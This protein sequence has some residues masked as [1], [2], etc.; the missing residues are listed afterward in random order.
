MDPIPEELIPISNPK[1]TEKEIDRFI[2]NSLALEALFIHKLFNKAHQEKSAVYEKS[3][4]KNKSPEEQKT[5]KK[6]KAS[7]EEIALEEQ[8]ALKE[9]KASEEQIASEE[10]RAF[11]KQKDKF[12]QELLEELNQVRSKE[13]QFSKNCNGDY[14]I[15]NLINCYTLNTYY[16][17]LNKRLLNFE[18]YS[19][20]VHEVRRM[21]EIK[22][23]K[24]LYTLIRRTIITAF[25]GDYDNAAK[26]V[27]KRRILD[28]YQGMIRVYSSLYG[29]TEYNKSDQVENLNLWYMNVL[30]YTQ[31]T[32]ID[33]TKNK[34]IQNGQTEYFYSLLQ[35]FLNIYRENIQST[36]ENE[37]K[38]PT[39]KNEEKGVT[40]ESSKNI[41]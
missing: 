16:I 7:K 25:Y 24:T 12:E 1:V 28:I 17:H 5:L 13:S 23:T 15:L 37:K 39:T 27:L 9:Q 40:S 29:K 35:D 20:T 38:D 34:F 8:R 6:Q 14:S 4:E 2:S 19:K 22:L 30:S 33:L 18:T 26:A 11:K 31:N 32:M 21:F 41:I 3:L 36:I 10:Q